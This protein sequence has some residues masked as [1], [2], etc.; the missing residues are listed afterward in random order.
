M[1]A[2]RPG[3]ERAPPTDDPGVPPVHP[4]PLPSLGQSQVPDSTDGDQGCHCQGCHEPYG[5]P[6]AT[7]AP[8]LGRRAYGQGSLRP[9]FGMQHQWQRG[10]RGHGTFRRCCVIAPRRG[11]PALTWPDVCRGSWTGSGVYLRI[12]S[13]AYPF[14]EGAQYLRDG[15]RVL[16]AKFQKQRTTEN[17]IDQAAKARRPVE[18]ESMKGRLW[19]LGEV[20]SKVNGEDKDRGLR[21]FL[22]SNVATTVGALTIGP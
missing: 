9:G 6:S 14:L 17:A 22:K 13:L 18:D 4:L 11:L 15:S 5:I 10:R 3:I 7:T 2:P 1:G 8:S 21:H 19:P 20:G 16:A 12:F